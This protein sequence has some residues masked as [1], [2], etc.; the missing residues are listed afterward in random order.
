MIEAIVYWGDPEQ[1][2]HVDFDEYI[3]MP[4][5]CTSAVRWAEHDNVAVDDP[6]AFLEFRGRDS[7]RDIPIYVV[8]DDMMVIPFGR[9]TS[10]LLVD[11]TGRG[12]GVASQEQTEQE[13]QSR[14]GPAADAAS[15]Q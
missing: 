8:A 12:I 11:R 9:H 4:Y 1:L 15:G 7:L 5:D 10:I 2:S 6:A 14:G 3:A 13:A